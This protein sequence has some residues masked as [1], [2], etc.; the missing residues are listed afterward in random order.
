MWHEDNSELGCDFCSASIEIDPQSEDNEELLHALYRD[1][2]D[3]VELALAD[4]GW[5][6]ASG[7]W[8]DAYRFRCGKCVHKVAVEM[9]ERTHDVETIGALRSRLETVLGEL[10]HV[11]GEVEAVRLNDGGLRPG[12]PVR[13]VAMQRRIQAVIDL[14][15]IP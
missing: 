12:A 3:E 9:A 6:L 14:P 13:L 2:R 5:G 15:P 10:R 1:D 7:D 4:R 8:P 11:V